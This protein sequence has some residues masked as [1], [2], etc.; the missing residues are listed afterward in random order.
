[1][2]NQPRVKKGLLASTGTSANQANHSSLNNAIVS[3]IT[4]LCADIMSDLTSLKEEI[5][6]SVDTKIDTLAT[7]L[8]SDISS[9]L[10]ELCGELASVRSDIGILTS[11]MTELEKGVNHWADETAFLEHKVHS[12]TKQVAL[13]SDKCED[14]EG[15]SHRNNL[16]SVGLSEG[17]KGQCPTDFIAGLLKDVL[18]QEENH[19]LIERTALCSH[20]PSSFGCT[21]LV[22]S[23]IAVCQAGWSA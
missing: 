6:A 23:I 3:A 1:M 8:R 18:Q 16:R 20:V 15:R 14:L 5:Y 11:R 7:S 19:Y 21:T 17:V 10:T 12:L 2:P 13:L 4:S 22:P 9:A